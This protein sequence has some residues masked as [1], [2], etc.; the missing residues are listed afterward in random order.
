MPVPAPATAELLK[1]V[2]IYGGTI[3]GELCTPTGAALL[4]Y[5]VNSFGPMPTL[6]VSAIGC[7]MGRKDF[8]AA[9]CVRAMLGETEEA[10][11]GRRSISVPVAEDGTEEVLELHCNLDDMTAED[12]AFAMERLLEAG[13]L[14]VWTQP[15]GMK[16]SRAGTMLCVLCKPND[17]EALLALLFRHTTTLGV[18][19]AALRRAVLDRR[20]ETVQTQFGPV[21]RKVASGFGVERA[22]YE[23]EDLARIAREQGLSLET[24]RAVLGGEDAG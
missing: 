23:Y 14:D 9:N 22:K 10:S 16:K 6:R 18:R 21:R 8:P 5:Y 15:I 11:T 20:V 1:G 12:L 13:A 19:E 17:R 4:K 7:G 24:V 2:P 3:Q